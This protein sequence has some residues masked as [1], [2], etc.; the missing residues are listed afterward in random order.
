MRDLPKGLVKAL[1][2]LRELHPG[3]LTNVTVP[4]QV[5]VVVRLG[6]VWAARQ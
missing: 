4:K 2:A 3:G 5:A 6:L 1:L